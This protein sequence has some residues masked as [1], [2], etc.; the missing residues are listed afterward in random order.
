V[1]RRLSL[2]GRAIRLRLSGDFILLSPSS[3]TAARNAFVL[4]WSVGFDRTHQFRV[5]PEQ[6]L[7]AVAIAVER[8]LAI[9]SIH[10]RIERGMSFA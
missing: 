8:L 2:T 10:G 4:L 9:E 6:V 3:F 1:G 5:E 7:D